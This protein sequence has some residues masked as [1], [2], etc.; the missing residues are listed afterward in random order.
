MNVSVCNQLTQG[1][2][3]NI[4]ILNFL[5]EKFFC[6]TNHSAA[7]EYHHKTFFTHWVQRSDISEGH[8]EKSLLNFVDTNLQSLIQAQSGGWGY[9]VCS[10]KEKGF[11]WGY[12]LGTFSIDPLPPLCHCTRSLWSYSS[13]LSQLGPS[14]NISFYVFHCRNL[15]CRIIFTLR[16]WHTQLRHSDFISGSHIQ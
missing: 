15:W 9:E 3:Q 2:L 10:C 8:F 12:I 7:P 16:L 13:S 4:H 5:Q 14:E 6:K 1:Q 11:I